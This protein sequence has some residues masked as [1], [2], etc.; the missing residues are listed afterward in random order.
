MV[1]LPFRDWRRALRRV[2]LRVIYRAPGEREDCPACGSHDLFDL[3]V[4]PLRAGRTGFVCGCD[5][6]GLVFS[7]PLPPP[8]HLAEFYSPT[9]LADIC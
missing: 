5:A 2:S 3:D 8:D 9:G 4:L 7:N 1:A 6:C